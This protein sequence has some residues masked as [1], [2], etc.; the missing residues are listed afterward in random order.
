MAKFC[1]ATGLAP[2][3]FWQLT[4]EEYGAMIE[5]LNRRK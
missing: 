4:F 3:D 5:E 2:K 1:V